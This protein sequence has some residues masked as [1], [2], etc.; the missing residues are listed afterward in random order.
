MA[1]LFVELRRRD[2]S[3]ATLAWF[4]GEK[5][6]LFRNH[7]QSPLPASSRAVFRGLSYWPCD[8]AARVQ[9]RLVPVEPEPAPVEA[10]TPLSRIGRLEFEYGGASVSLAAFWVQGYAGGLL[11]PFRD[12]TSGRETYGGGRYL[13][14]SIKSA[15]LGSDLASETV[16]LDFNYAYYP[17]CAYDPKWSCP[18]APP[19]N[20]LRARVEAGERD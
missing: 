18:L 1:E 5:D 8:P 14:D 20:W 9:A 17:S 12:A 19:S 13:I 10:E 16:T 6:E 2:P 4:R 11:V 15:D 7:L 3:E